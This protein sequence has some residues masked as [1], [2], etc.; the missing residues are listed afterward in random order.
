MPAH[1]ARPRLLMYAV[2]YRERRVRLF[3]DYLNAVRFFTAQPYYNAFQIQLWK[4]LVGGWESLAYT[5]VDR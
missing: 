5:P 1:G 2:R 4:L 3:H